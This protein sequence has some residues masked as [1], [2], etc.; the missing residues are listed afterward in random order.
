MTG[1]R[2][3]VTILTGTLGA[4]KTTLVN[5]ILSGNHGRRIAV[6]VNEIGE[7]GIDGDLIIGAEEEMV[8]LSN[9]CICCT[10]RGDL[11]RTL[12]D[13]VA[14]TP[15][16]DAIVI[17]TTGLADP[18]PVVQTFLADPVLQ[19]ATALDGV[20]T[21]V[22]AHHAM[23]QLAG[24][25]EA[26]QQ[27][28][29]ADQI[30]LNK[31][32]LASTD[33]LAAIERALRRINAPAPIH[34]AS[35][36]DVPLDAVLGR[37]AFDLARIDTLEAGHPDTHCHEPEHVHDEHCAHHHDDHIAASGIA[38]VSL[39]S[40]VPLDQAKLEQWLGD[41]LATQGADILRSK[42]VLDIAGDD[43]RLV[44]Q[45]VHMLHEGDW[46]RPWRPGEQRTSRL[47][48]I[49]RNLDAATLA[50]GFAGC[51]ASAGA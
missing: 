21:V 7:I 48:L 47:V 46:Q 45:S 37:G 51:A 31:A 3:P 9:G 2:I 8:Q 1:A 6:V 43:R 50:A 32:E 49:G 42:G 18:G 38:T 4:G 30:V 28:A 14:R 24:S 44:V 39:T 34:R 5:R 41:L 26:A 10:I 35:R 22:D 25:R 11:V 15:Q 27:V 17:E 16:P 33:Q 19:E 13:L 29:F 20:T 40:I 12:R 36:S 23:H